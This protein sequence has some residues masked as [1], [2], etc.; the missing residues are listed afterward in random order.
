MNKL[1]GLKAPLFCFFFWLIIAPVFGQ[2]SFE[3]GEALFIQDRPSEA[4]EFLEAAIAEDPDHVQAFLYLGVAYHQLGM[5]EEA[6]A[7]YL[8]IIPNGGIETARL[9]FNLGNAYLAQGDLHLAVQSYGQ[10]LE[11]NPE[12]SP[13]LLNRANTYVQLHLIE[14]QSGFLIE[15]AADYEN[16]LS[17]E[18]G[19][20]QAGQIR[21][22]IFFIREEERLRQEAIAAE[23]QRRLAMDDAARQEEERRQRFLQGVTASS[24]A[25][26]GDSRNLNPEGHEEGSELAGEEAERRQRFLQGVA[27]SAWAMTGDSINLFATQGQEEEG[28]S[29][30]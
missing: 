16:F 3:Q 11:E 8:R 18:D 29:D 28:E 12:F 2:T 13:A 6:I 26:A 5:I 4:L 19:S 7:A 23:V 1:L 14:P 24:Q 22:L 27:A 15:A 21:G 10:A 25:I 20:S 9:A 30:N 17:L